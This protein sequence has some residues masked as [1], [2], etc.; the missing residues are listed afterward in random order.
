[1]TKP[2]ILQRIIEPGIVA[3]IRADSSDQLLA[4]CEA[5][6]AGGISTIE[7]TMTTPNAIQVIGDVTAHFE[8]Q[9]L[10][11]VGS[12][13][14]AETARV[15]MLAGAEFVVT[16]VTKVDV[17]RLC[18]RYGKPIISGA[19]TPTE[20]LLGHESGADF[21]K[22]FPSDHVG[23]PYIKNLLAPMPMLQIIPTGGITPENVA[24]FI[25]AGAVALGVAS[26]LVSG[27]TI[28]KRD[29]KKLTQSAKQFVAAVKA[30]RA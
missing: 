19:F 1:M 26:S 22:L 11:G 25:E 18:N 17:I 7:V 4:V 10:M 27:E 30:A 21:I 5:L 6:L 29:W 28:K 24:A 8:G 23:A 14:D 3:I 15:A 2:E 12:V 9:I 20:A 13:L 16:P